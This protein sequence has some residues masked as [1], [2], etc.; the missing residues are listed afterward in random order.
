MVR[1]F[2]VGAIVG[3]AVVWLYGREIRQ[4]IDDRTLTART[5]AAET[6]KSAAEGLQSAKEKIE[7]GLTG[8]EGRPA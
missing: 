4:F 7:G 5:R 3:G 6:L 2:L 1:S 8:G